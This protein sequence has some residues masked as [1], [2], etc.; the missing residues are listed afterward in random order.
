LLSNAVKFTQEGYVCLRASTKPLDNDPA[1]VLLQLAVEDSGVGIPEERL[2]SIFD[3]FTQGDQTGDTTQG[4]GLGLAICRSL[5]DVMEGRIDVTSKPGKGS[6]FTLMVPVETAEASAFVHEDT[7]KTQ[8]VG[9]KPGQT[10]KR[11]LVADDNADNRA[12]LTNMLEQVGFTV[13]EVVDGETAIEAFNSWHTHLICMDMRMPVMD[14][15]TATETIRK[16]P[17]GEQVKIIAVTASVF[18][19]QRDKILSAGCDELVCKP[20]RESEIFDA[21]GRLIDVE[22]LYSDAT[23]LP[24]PEETPKLTEKMLSEIPPELISELRQATLV[25]DRKTM[26][27]LIERIGA[28]APDTA[29]ALQRLV[30]DFQFERIKDLLGDMI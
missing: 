28:H 3:S 15:Y 4:T 22:Y 9:L 13:R 10:P 19:E 18:E 6:L 23:Q 11:I 20:V 1:G 30:D 12:L 24:A 8:V 21:I 7:R 14:G 17:G 27:G 25:L 5:A 2:D 16:L 29:K 26:A